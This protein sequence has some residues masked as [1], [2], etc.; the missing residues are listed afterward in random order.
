MG[1]RPCQRIHIVAFIRWASPK[2]VYIPCM[3]PR[4]H[5]A[6]VGNDCD[7]RSSLPQPAGTV[8]ADAEVQTRAGFE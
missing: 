2:T 3:A 6:C 4:N 5:A 8:R 1:P 7:A